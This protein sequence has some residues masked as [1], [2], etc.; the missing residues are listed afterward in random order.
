[1]PDKDKQR[2]LIENC[3]LIECFTK[4]EDDGTTTFHFQREYCQY[5]LDE[6]L[7]PTG[8]GQAAVFKNG[9][10]LSYKNCCPYPD[11]DLITMGYKKISTNEALDILIND[12]PAN[13][14]EVNSLCY[15]LADLDTYFPKNDTDILN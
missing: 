14:Y 8:Q 5:K 4:K 10:I 1:M 3:K 12:D 2:Q 15:S 13:E 11:S 6:D 9:R 7:I